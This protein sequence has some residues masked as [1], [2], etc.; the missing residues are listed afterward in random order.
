MSTKSPF[1]WGGRESCTRFLGRTQVD[2]P[3][4][5]TISSSVLEQL[6]GVTNRQLETSTHTNTDHA[7]SATRGRI[8]ALGA[9]NAA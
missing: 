3:N 7:T 1:S 4:G 2:I 8:F 6:A 9:R 5:I